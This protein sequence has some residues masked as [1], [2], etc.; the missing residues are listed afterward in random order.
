MTFR[1]RTNSGG[2]LILVIVCLFVCLFV[3][4]F[5]CFAVPSLRNIFC[6]TN[7]NYKSYFAKGFSVDLD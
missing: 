1:S 7:K 6:V 3:G 4:L 2:E 5:V